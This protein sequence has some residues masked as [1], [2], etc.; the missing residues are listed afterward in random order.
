[1]ACGSDIRML[2]ASGSWEVI[3][4]STGG[5][6]GYL[7]FRLKQPSKVFSRRPIGMVRHQKSNNRRYLS[8]DGS[9]NLILLKSS[10]P[11]SSFTSPAHPPAAVSS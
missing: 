4:S 1:M 9:A 10:F 5:T 3:H 6:H 7:L 11:K 8:L 2:R